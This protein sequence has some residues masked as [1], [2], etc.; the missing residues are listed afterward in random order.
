MKNVAVISRKLS[1][2]AAVQNDDDMANLTSRVASNLNELNQPFGP[3]TLTE[4]ADLSLTTL[5]QVNLMINF[6]KEQLQE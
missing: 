1:E 5:E 6:A 2:L 3:R 4:V